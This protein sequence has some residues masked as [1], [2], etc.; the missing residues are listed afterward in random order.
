MYYNESEASKHKNLKRI[1]VLLVLVFVFYVFFQLFRSWPK[2]EFRLTLKNQQIPGAFSIS[3]PT[4]IRYGVIGTLQSGIIAKTPNQ[5]QWPLASVAKIMTSYIILKDHP[6]SIGQDGPSFTI[7]QKEVNE[8]EAFKKD[9]QSVVKV[10]LGEK[11]TE[12]Q[13]LEGLMIPSANNF[14]YILA[15]WDAGSVKAFVDKM[16]KTAQ[17]LGLKDTHYEDPAGANAGTVSSPVD[18]FRLTQLA[19]QIP[20][21]RHIV[22]MPQV[23]L[24]VAGIQYNVN[25]DLGKD[26]IV[27]VKTG[28]SLPAG[29]NFVFDSKQGNI[30]ILGVIFG[31]SGKSPLTSAL[32][33]AITLIDTAKTQV[34]EQ[35]LISKNEQVGFIKVPWDKKEIPLLASEDFN[36]V[37]YP[38]MKISYS[39]EPIK[40]IKFPI[41]QNEIIANLII[42]YGDSSFNMPLIASQNIKSPSFSDRL[43]RIL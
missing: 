25:Y 11:L 4:D 9:G 40:D 22:A 2:P 36:L 6:L 26:N 5:G 28:S 42:T 3:W 23:N 20:T 14:A 19:M 43:R 18:Q 12:R 7:T 17:A 37:V 30:D 33:D 15:R 39:I 38:G 10:S 34:S 21:F 13:L 24:P 41:K 29:A 8:Y 27:G 31:A 35:K 32:K 16:N 1:V